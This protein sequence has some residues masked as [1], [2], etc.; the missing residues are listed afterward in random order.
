MDGEG[1]GFGGLYATVAIGLPRGGILIG[2]HGLWISA[3]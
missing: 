1:G 2:F 3:S